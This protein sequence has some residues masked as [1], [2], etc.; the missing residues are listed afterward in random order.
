MPNL[1]PRIERLEATHPQPSRPT[2][3]FL[4][5]PDMTDDAI[6]ELERQGEAEGVDVMVIQLT[7][8]EF[9]EPRHGEH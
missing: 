4:C 8:G 1:K 6:A 2:R 9:K 3:T 7:P 5:G